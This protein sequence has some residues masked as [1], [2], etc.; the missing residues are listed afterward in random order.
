MR[1]VLEVSTCTYHANGHWISTVHILESTIYLFL[2]NWHYMPH[3][4]HMVLQKP[5]AD[6]SML[7]FVAYF[8]RFRYYKV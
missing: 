1:Y 6:N 2:I 4:E 5:Y 8:Y 3:C 7:T